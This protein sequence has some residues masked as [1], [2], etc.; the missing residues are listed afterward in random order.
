MGTVTFRGQ[1]LVD[2]GTLDSGRVLAATYGSGF[3]QEATG[4]WLPSAAEDSWS[5]I[6]LPSRTGRWTQAEFAT[7]EEAARARGLSPQVSH[8][9]RFI[10]FIDFDRLGDGFGAPVADALRSAGHDPRNAQLISGAS[11]LIQAREYPAIL[12]GAVRRAAAGGRPVLPE[13]AVDHLRAAYDSVYPEIAARDAGLALTANRP[14]DVRGT[15]RTSFGGTP[16]RTTAQT[17]AAATYGA[18]NPGEDESRLESALKTGGLALATGLGVRA[19]TAR[20]AGMAASRAG[21]DAARVPEPVPALTNTHERILHGTPDEIVGD[22]RPSPAINADGYPNDLGEG[23]YATTDRATAAAYAPGGDV[24]RSDYELREAATRASGHKGRIYTFEGAEGKPIRTLAMFQPMDAAEVA[25]VRAALQELAPEAVRV[26]DGFAVAMKRRPDGMT[27]NLARL[28]VET[29]LK[30]AGATVKASDVF[31][32]AG[33]DGFESNWQMTVWNPK[34]R[35]RMV[36]EE[37]LGRFPVPCFRSGA[38]RRVRRSR[39]RARCAVSACTSQRSMGRG[40]G[41]AAVE[42]GGY[43]PQGGL[44]GDAARR[45]WRSLRF[46][47]RPRER[48]GRW[49]CSQSTAYTSQPTNGSSGV[50]S[51]VPRNDAVAK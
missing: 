10:E 6:V 23:L 44:P 46:E 8:D 1:I 25:A 40:R 18:L 2:D 51:N 50:T 26:W 35:L 48:R 42:S 7:I 41:T 14:G 19:A 5:G 20:Q 33:W 4:L 9:G 24:M 27:G 38:P 17:A 12:E 21:E 36:G 3:R 45:A 39:S 43:A 16:L 11:E 34:Q 30:Q 28:G 22:I 37:L 31:M 49:P 47:R 13:R 29:A 15:L 32:R